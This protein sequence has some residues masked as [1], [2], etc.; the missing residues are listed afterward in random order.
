MKYTAQTNEDSKGQENNAVTENDDEEESKGT[1][2]Q[3]GSSKR[4]R[5][6]PFATPKKKAKLSK[7]Q[8]SRDV[9][10]SSSNVYHSQVADTIDTG[11]SPND[12]AGLTESVGGKLVRPRNN[13]QHSDHP[14]KNRKMSAAASVS[15][16]DT[17]MAARTT[18][19]SS[20]AKM[21]GIASNTS[22]DNGISNDSAS[23]EEGAWTGFTASECD[24]ANTNADAVL[25]DRRIGR[26][27]LFALP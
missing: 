15:D 14:P 2:S 23:E 21:N 7:L 13:L 3:K 9:T 4:T 25:N 27:F 10:A 5:I 20:A 16:E 18:S 12:D 17:S 24:N 22:V 8:S 1:S 19:S 6:D 26:V 11:A